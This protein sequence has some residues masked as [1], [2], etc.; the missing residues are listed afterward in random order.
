LCQDFAKD[1]QD[2]QFLFA[3]APV[4]RQKNQVIVQKTVNRENDP[5]ADSDELRR[6][7]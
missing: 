4:N 6:S 3:E 1:E 5:T 2:S 7:S